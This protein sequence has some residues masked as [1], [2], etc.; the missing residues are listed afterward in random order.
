MQFPC[1]PRTELGEFCIAFPCEPTSTA[2]QHDRQSTDLDALL[3]DDILPIGVLHIDRDWRGVGYISQPAIL[4][5]DFG[6]R[7]KLIL[8]YRSPQKAV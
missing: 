4:W 3:L 1:R 2:S 8:L 6:R 7:A 5:R